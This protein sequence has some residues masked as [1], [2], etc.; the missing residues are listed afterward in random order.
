MAGSPVPR[1]SF[2]KETKD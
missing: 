1:T 2:L